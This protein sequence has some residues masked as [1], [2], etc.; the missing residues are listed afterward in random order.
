DHSQFGSSFV[1]R[2]ALTKVVQDVHFKLLYSRAFRAPGIENIRLNPSIKPE[3]T[4]VYEFETG[5]QMSDTMFVSLN[6]FNI[7]INKPIVYF[8][9]SV[10][11]LEGYRNYDRT[12]TRG[13]ETVYRI[14]DNWGHADLTYSYYAENNNEVDSYKA[15][16]KESVL[17]GFPAHKVTLNTSVR[18]AKRTTLNPSAI[19]LSRRYGYDQADANGDAQFKTAEPIL[20]LNLFL[21]F[22]DVFTRGLTIGVGGYNLSNENYRYIQPYNNAH[23]PLPGP[24][25]ELLA[26]VSY[27]FSLR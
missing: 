2:M 14:K 11:G 3:K 24:S 25:R 9:D 12:G 17:L 5:Y 27:A 10:S 16:T 19:Y 1:P 21:N 26:K 23:P 6:L 8:F 4:T 13:L 15:G 20:L 7:R 18:V 22:R